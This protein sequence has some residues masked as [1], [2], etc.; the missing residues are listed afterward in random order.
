MGDEIKMNKKDLQIGD[1]IRLRRVP[2][3][4]QVREDATGIFLWNKCKKGTFDM[5]EYDDNLNYIIDDPYG[6]FDTKDYDVME[7]YDNSY[8]LVA[9]RNEE[10]TT[11]CQSLVTYIR[12]YIDESVND[13][14]DISYSCNNCHTPI[15]HITNYCPTC[16]AKIIRQVCS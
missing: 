4:F 5:G 10:T 3:L 14:S 2:Y 6:D 15:K 12:A 13:V 16:G 8:R 9:S 1:I 11:S 7:I